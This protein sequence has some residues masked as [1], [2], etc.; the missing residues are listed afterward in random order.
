MRHNHH[1][2]PW[3]RPQNI[4]IPMLTGLS[5]CYPISP[6][7]WWFGTFSLFPYIENFIIPTD[8]LISLRGVGQPPTSHCSC[9]NPP[10]VSGKP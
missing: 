1:G 8:E 5:P 3:S 9:L 7:G 6:S 2:H 10:F 4:D